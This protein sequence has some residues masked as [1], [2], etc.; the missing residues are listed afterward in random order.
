MD[1]LGDDNG[2]FYQN[3]VDEELNEEIQHN[4]LGNINFV[5]QTTEQV[6]TITKENTNRQI[7]KK[8]KI[9]TNYVCEHCGFKTVSKRIYSHHRA[10]IH[11]S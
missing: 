10:S 1:P 5:E 2:M 11:S 3:N 7:T 4:E 8:K 9:D 6:T